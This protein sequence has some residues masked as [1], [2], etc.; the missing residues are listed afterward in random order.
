MRESIPVEKEAGENYNRKMLKKKK[1]KGI[2]NIHQWKNKS[3]VRAVS[4]NTES[5]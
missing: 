2:R 5:R 3:F 1:K 4:E